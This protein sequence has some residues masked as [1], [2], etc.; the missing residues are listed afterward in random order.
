MRAA[1]MTEVRKPWSIKNLPDPKPQAGQVLIRIRAS[2]MCGTDLHVH[3]GVM[4]VPLGVV[5]GYSLLPMLVG[6]GKLSQKER[7][8]PQRHMGLHQKSWIVLTLSQ[9][10]KFLS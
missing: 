9:T 8:V 2:G 7:G 5:E 3:H 10:E 4:A 6:R 1:V